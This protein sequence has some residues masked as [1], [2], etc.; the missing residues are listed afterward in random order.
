[1]REA[2]RVGN[3]PFAEERDAAIDLKTVKSRL[4]PTE[5]A[6]YSSREEKD[7]EEFGLIKEFTGPE[8]CEQS[9]ARDD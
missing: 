6:K 5:S 2:K 7:F 3:A 4:K 1:V 8:Y 9:D